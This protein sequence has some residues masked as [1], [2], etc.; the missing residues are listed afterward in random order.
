[1]S[2]YGKMRIVQKYSKRYVRAMSI[3]STPPLPPEVLSGLDDF[4][5]KQPDISC[6]SLAIN[7]I[8]M[9]WLIDKGHIEWGSENGTKTTIGCEGIHGSLPDFC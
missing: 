6:R 1:M 3:H 5:A 8:L 9:D 7:M 2:I 4:V